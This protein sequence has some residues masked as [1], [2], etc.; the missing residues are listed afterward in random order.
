MA[1]SGNRSTRMLARYTH[2][3]EERKADAIGS[4]KLVPR[5]QTGHKRRMSPIG[6]WRNCRNC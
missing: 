2:A 3:T 1:V 4:F 5:S 6:N